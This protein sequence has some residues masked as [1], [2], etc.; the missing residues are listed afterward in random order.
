MD[1]L[2]NKATV[3]DISIRR[4]ESWDPPPIDGKQGA[5]KQ[6]GCLLC[7]ESRSE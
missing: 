2:Y 5:E 4:G 6:D 1:Y 3:V 7:F